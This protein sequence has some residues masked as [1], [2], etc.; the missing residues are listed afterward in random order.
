MLIET[1]KDYKAEQAE[2]DEI[3]PLLMDLGRR[4]DWFE[5]ET[6]FP[7]FG[8][9]VNNDAIIDVPKEATAGTIRSRLLNLTCDT[10]TTLPYTLKATH[11]S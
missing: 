8:G 7:M 10:L 9:V 11:L 4:L 3:I 6:L 2:V 1:Y 5:R